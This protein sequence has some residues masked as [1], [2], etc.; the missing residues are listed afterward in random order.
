MKRHHPSLLC[1]VVI[2]LFY[3]NQLSAQS[4]FCFTSA[5]D[6]AISTG[7]AVNSIVIRD[8]NGD[9]VPDVA[10]ANLKT[11]N[12]TILPGR[13]DRSFREPEIVAQISQPWILMS[14]DFN[15]DG[16]YDLAVSALDNPLTILLGDGNGK[17]ET[18]GTYTGFE[19]ARVLKSGDF[20]KDG[21]VD[22]VAFRNKTKNISV[23]F[24]DGTG[25]FGPYTDI[26][27]SP[28]NFVYDIISAD[29]TSDGFED[30]A[31]IVSK[32]L[33]IVDFNTAGEPNDHVVLATNARQLINADFNG[34]GKQ[35][36]YLPDAI[37]NLLLGNGA[38]GF[39][40][41]NTVT[42]LFVF[43]G[44]VTGYFNDDEFIDVAGTDPSGGVR[45]LLATTATTFEA[46]DML[47][48]A[49]SN[50]GSIATD[51]MDADG[52]ADILVA[53]G[54]LNMGGI[55]VLY[56]DIDDFTSTETYV[57][58]NDEAGLGIYDVNGDGRKDLIVPNAGEATVSVLFQNPDGRFGTAVKSSAT[59]NSEERI[60][61]DYNS[62]GEVDI[63]SFNFSGKIIMVYGNGDGTFTNGP[64]YD[65]N[66]GDI[67]GGDFDGDNKPDL[68]VTIKSTNFVGVM[69]NDGAGG[70]NKIDY[71]SG[72]FATSVYTAD[73]NGDGKLDII[74][75]V[76]N[77]NKIA[78]LTGKGDGTFNAV[79]NIPTGVTLE[80]LNYFFDLNGDGK[81]DMLTTNPIDVIPF[82]SPY[83][84][85]VMI[86]LG[87][88]FP[89]S[90]TID[91]DYPI[92]SIANGDFDG[93]G[94]I[95]LAFGGLN[96]HSLW[97]YPGN[98]DGTFDSP[99]LFSSGSSDWVVAGDIDSDGS[100]DLIASS[101]WI[102]MINI[103]RNNTARITPSGSVTNCIGNVTLKASNNGF[104]Y[105][106]ATPEGPMSGQTIVT[107][108]RGNYTLVVSNSSQLCRTITDI[109]IEGKPA[110]PS[111]SII[112][113]T[114]TE[115]TGS[116]IVE[117]QLNDDVYSFDNGLNFQTSNVKTGLTP[118]DY[119]VIIKSADGCSSK[120]STA[121][122]D[123]QPT[124]PTIPVVETADPT[125]ETHTGTV[126]V[127]IQK[128][129]D[130]YSFDG[131][132]TFL[133][134]NRN[135]DL[136]PGKYKILIRRALDCVSDTT[137]ATI[138]HGPEIPSKPSV[139]MST[140]VEPASLVS[141]L[142]PAYEWSKDGFPID[143]ATSQEYTPASTGT[144]TVVVFS[145]DGCRSEPSDGIS[146]V[147][148]GDIDELVTGF[149]P[150]PTDS[151]IHYQTTSGSVSSVIYT[152][153]GKQIS[154]VPTR[155]AAELIYD[156][157][158]FTP[159]VYV[160][161][162]TVDNAVKTIRWVKR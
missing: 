79:V 81:A 133:G 130:T 12:V 148:N 33:H 6:Y 82:S 90:T 47:F 100:L 54:D 122:I 56:N 16:K 151:Y 25:K 66:V 74:S 50:P 76:N 109:T 107:D 21:N 89:V 120:V 28:N 150:N 53:Q 132:R 158:D 127:T 27:L 29:F 139:T 42:P 87:S 155:T 49:G 69:L 7:S 160:L 125:C 152:S 73:I 67:A 5:S 97:V 110:L 75:L 117:K 68:V 105:Q 134:T 22:I 10:V 111:T 86:N 128:E 55:L 156:V 146:T 61:G 161:K 30:V 77:D 102:E 80:A 84:L 154:I 138:N 26:A 39:P 108:V 2:A 101:A 36:L 126:I 17:F 85:N 14:E 104:N 41:R 13:G 131:G 96:L 48:D 72:I 78:V 95:D 65:Y 124:P 59:I 24:G 119:S 123:P 94:A 60:Y 135:D 20:N 88:L 15:N 112:N 157:R 8:F 98:D 136:I 142:A 45:V 129:G 91:V 99:S 35:D 9:N 93:D 92:H 31:F 32:N 137:K 147:I 159:G 18:A 3:T 143:G 62:D 141:S 103:F 144:Y 23:M 1:L 145:T 37:D 34:D 113:T 106:W 38:A 153:G 70:F 52:R 83:K 58:D 140:A 44:L 63:A 51:D 19:S 115:T 11:N 64:Q 118:G 4:P 46:K 116:L 162:L 71:S 43:D 57:V 149:Y 121:T 114:C 40:T